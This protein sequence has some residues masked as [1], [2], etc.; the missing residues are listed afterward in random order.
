[1]KK[2]PLTKVQKE[3][4]D[5]LHLYYKKKGYMPTIPEILKRFKLFSTNSGFHR[6]EKLSKKGWIKRKHNTPRNITIL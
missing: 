4:L 5:F 2:E 6:L 1:M 3:T